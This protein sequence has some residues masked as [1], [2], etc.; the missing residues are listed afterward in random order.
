MNIGIRK[1]NLEKRIKARTTAKVKRSVK[2]F[3]NPFYGRK[4]MGW[5]KNPKK[6]LYNKAYKKLTI[7]A[8]DV[9]KKVTEDNPIETPTNVL[10]IIGLFIKLGF[11]IFLLVCLIWFI[12]KV[13]L[14]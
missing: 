12:I 4:G 3:I 7:S 9:V 13:I 1:P 14:L 6:A 2:S 8:D 5:I 11:N 10:G